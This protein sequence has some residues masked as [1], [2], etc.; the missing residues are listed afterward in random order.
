VVGLLFKVPKKSAEQGKARGG[1]KSMESLIYKRIT[2]KKEE[3][4]RLLKGEEESGVL[5]LEVAGRAD[6]KENNNGGV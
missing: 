1:D 4:L 5:S 3:A 2:F 6:K